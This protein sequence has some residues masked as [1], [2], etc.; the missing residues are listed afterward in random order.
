[1]TARYTP[2]EEALLDRELEKFTVEYV[3]VCTALEDK[4][5]DRAQLEID[6]AEVLTRE[7]GGSGWRLT[8]D[9]PWASI[10]RLLR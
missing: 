7:W 1:M 8:T 5:R 2:E 4:Y 6:I 9:E 10:A 3:E